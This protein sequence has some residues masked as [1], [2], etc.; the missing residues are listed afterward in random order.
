M[1]DVGLFTFADVYRG[2]PL[3]PDLTVPTP[4]EIVA[5]LSAGDR[6]R[7]VEA[8]TAQ[9]HE[10]HDSALAAHLGGKH[11]AATA[12][13]FSGGSDS[14]VL[15]HL[16]R[17][18][19]THAI[20]A[21]TGIGIESTRQFVRDVCAAW[22]LPLLEPRAEGKDSYRALV[23]DQGFPGPGHHFK[24]YQRLKER[25][26]RKAQRE[27]LAG[28][29]GARV[30]YLAGRR[31]AESSRRAEIPLHERVGSVIWASPLAMWT[32]LDLN[33][34]RD[35]HGDDVP[36]PCPASALIHMSGECLCGAFAHE[37]ELDEVGLF[38]P[39]VVEEI[40]SLEADVRAAGWEEPYCRWGHG[41]GKASEVGALCSSCDSRFIPGQTDLLEDL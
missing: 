41:Q 6:V 12:L 34:Y 39:E 8:L 5:D 18:S 37:G 20:H 2:D 9:A 26:L 38:F 30:L 1:S 40:R 15:A 24:M 31:R 17:G 32:K 21:N 13:L 29:R 19:A 35:I 23:L 7:R 36:G 10:I 14:T 16:L 33:T 4:A 27:L 25:Q 11:L 28:Q 3:D 22:D